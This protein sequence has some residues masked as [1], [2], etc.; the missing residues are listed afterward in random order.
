MKTSFTTA[1][2]CLAVFI[3]AL[4]PTADAVKITTYSVR[5]DGSSEWYTEERDLQKQ[6]YCNRKQ[7]SNKR[8]TNC[9]RKKCRIKKRGAIGRSTGSRKGVKTA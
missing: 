4:V 7:C 9:D 5:G 1:A 3:M 8:E 2:V 6:E